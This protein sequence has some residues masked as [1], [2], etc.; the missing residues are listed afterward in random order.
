MRAGFPAAASARVARGM[1]AALDA[2]SAAL[3]AEETALLA[4]RAALLAQQADLAERHDAS[5]AWTNERAPHRFATR[6][7]GRA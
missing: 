4:R 6:E 1:I 7:E 5:P 2:E 3:D